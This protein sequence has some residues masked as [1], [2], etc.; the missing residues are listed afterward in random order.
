MINQ[1]HLAH[2]AYQTDIYNKYNKKIDYLF[3][4]IIILLTGKNIADKVVMATDGMMD[5]EDAIAAPGVFA[6]EGV[7][8]T[9]CII[10]TDG[11]MSTMAN[12]TNFKIAKILDSYSKSKWTE[13]MQCIL[14]HLHYANP[15]D[16]LCKKCRHRPAKCEIC[17][18]LVEHSRHRRCISCDKQYRADLVKDRLEEE[19]QLAAEEQRK[20][21]IAEQHQR[22]AEEQRIALERQQEETNRTF[23]YLLQTDISILV[24]HIMALTKAN[25]FLDARVST[26]EKEIRSLMHT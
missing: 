14:C 13:N 10:A 20:R 12:Q 23:Q 1:T 6:M 3:N 8:S 21:E 16:G 5:T 11:M 22:D 24:K 9:D 15:T 7:M 26:L 19:Q 4:N 2:L 25:E 17:F 18:R